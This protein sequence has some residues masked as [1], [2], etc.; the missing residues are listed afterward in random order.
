MKWKEENACSKQ[1]WNTNLSPKSC[2][3]PCSRNRRNKYISKHIAPKK[4]VYLHG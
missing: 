3:I 2:Q 1:E 4:I